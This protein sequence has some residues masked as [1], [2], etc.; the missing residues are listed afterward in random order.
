MADECGE[1]EVYKTCGPVCRETCLDV[2]MKA[3]AGQ[4]RR[5]FS[6]R[7]DAGCFCKD[8]YVLD[9]LGENGKCIKAEDCP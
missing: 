8:G 6:L 7:C 3:P 5:C 1:N 2:K 9:S 4:S